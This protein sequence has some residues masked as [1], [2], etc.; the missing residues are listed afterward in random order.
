MVSCTTPDHAQ[1]LTITSST[2]AKQQW[3]TYMN[4]F[5]QR[6]T[7]EQTMS[8]PNILPQEAQVVPAKSFCRDKGCKIWS[9]CVRRV[10]HN[11]QAWHQTCLYICIA[12]AI[13]SFSDMMQYTPISLSPQP[14]SRL[15]KLQNVGH[16]AISAEPVHTNISLDL[17]SQSNLWVAHISRRCCMCSVGTVLSVLCS[18]LTASSVK[19]GSRS[20]H[21]NSFSLSYP[22]WSFASTAFHVF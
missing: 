9:V 19:A 21:W 12:I 15:V 16:C 3:P 7:D 17:V 14:C 4:R 5:A 2:D 13:P 10:A 11:A 6:F 8:W 18:N 22:R 1:R 20:F